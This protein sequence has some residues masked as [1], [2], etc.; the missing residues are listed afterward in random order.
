[1]S[2][3]KIAALTFFAF[4]KKKRKKRK[5]EPSPMELVNALLNNV[6]MEHDEEQHRLFCE[7]IKKEQD[8]K[9]GEGC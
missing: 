4:F 1:M 9:S 3:I 2:L 8:K 7:K 6:P 5:P